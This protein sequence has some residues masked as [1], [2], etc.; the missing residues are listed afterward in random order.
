MTKSPCK[1]LNTAA[2]KECF[3][4]M[5][6]S[7]GNNFQRISKEHP[8][9]CLKRVDDIPVGVWSKISRTIVSYPL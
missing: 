7:L 9:R 8:C 3:Q 1:G 5:I 6:L 4:R 2:S